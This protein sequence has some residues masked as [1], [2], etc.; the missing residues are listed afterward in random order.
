MDRLT[1]MGLFVRIVETGSFSAVAREMNMTQPTVSKQL[2]A[3]ERQ[4]KTR[5]LN[6]STR[7]LSLT[8]AGSAYFESSK[9]I[10]DTVNEAEANLGVLQTQLSGV[11]RVNSSI[12]LG[13]MY[14][15]PLLLKF[16]SM[17]PGLMIDL[18]LADRFV[19]L[20]EEGVDVAI[21][22]GRLVDSNLAA[23]RIGTSERCLI[24]T[25]AYLKKNGTP[26]TPQDL[27]NH[28]CILYAYLSTGNEW[29]FG[30]D[31]EIRVRVSGTLRANN[32][33]AIR[34]AVMADLGI[35]A[36][37]AWLI[38]D[39]LRSGRLQE[40]LR[41]YAPP[42]GEINAVY[43]SGRHVSAKVRAFTEFLKAEFEKIPALRVR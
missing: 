20:V 32:G 4:L 29:V 22:I 24:A 30:K 39:D 26:K 5:L 12:G 21:R 27:V 3:L 17:H 43:P 33:E 28:N 25:P 36:S 18:A 31:G 34:Q 9:R 2:T 8:E 42:P 1:A 7:Q 23:R 35:A 41:D 14:L 15:G 6:R 19:D 10:L 13:Q 40:I 16:Q 37:P 11:L 38:Q